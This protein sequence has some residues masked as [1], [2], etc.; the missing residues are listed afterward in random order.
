[1][2]GSRILLDVLHDEGVRHVFGNP[3]TTELPLIAELSRSAGPAYV[4]G[5]QESVVVAMAD[6]YAQ[7]SGRPAMVNLHAMAGLGNAIGNLTNARVQGTPLVVTAGQ[8]DQRHL[9]ADP[10]LAGD[11]TGL[12]APVSKWTHEVRRTE[13]LGVVMRRAFRDAASAPTGPVFVSLPVDV[14]ETEIPDPDATAVRTVSEL[15]RA[16]HGAPVTRL[17]DL[18]LETDPA[19]LAIVASDDVAT[20]HAVEEL[21]AVAEALGVRVYGSSLHANTVF[22]TGHPLWAGAFG[23]SADEIRATLTGYDRVLVLGGRAFMA[24]NYSPGPLVP[25]EVEILQIALDP[26]ELGRTAPVRLGL[27]GHLRTTLQDLQQVLAKRGDPAR[28]REATTEL[29]KAHRAA[30][31]AAE[32]HALSTYSQVPTAPAAAVHAVLRALPPDIIV[33][34]ESMT[35]DDHVRAFHRADRPGRYYTARGSGLGW[36]MP[37]AL[38]VSLARGNHPVL[39]L[40]GD[41]SAMYSPQALWTAAREQLPVLFVVVNNNQYLMLKNS[42][43]HRFPQH[44]DGGFVGMDIDRP[45]IDFVALARSMG[46]HAERVERATDIAEAAR[47]AWDS[48]GPRLLE[49]P[50]AAP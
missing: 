29:G 36:G 18:L 20:E 26:H 24:Y 15:D 12:A 6:G 8:A 13:D 42:L 46:V 4:L 21:V 23:L 27:A 22:P 28:A 3:G 7:A 14:L 38:G 49:L 35:C 17:A 32:A 2:R 25:P 5:L 1:M 40:V 50:I 33:V 48:R 16:P 45:A 43:R 9:V 19:R 47:A 11:L 30:R 37:A 41:G 34:D 10:L 44:P 31:D 39:C